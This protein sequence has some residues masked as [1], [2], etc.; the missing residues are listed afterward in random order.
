[1]TV[2]DGW[3]ERNLGQVADITMG[4][5]PDS[6]YYSEDEVGLPFLQGCAEFTA[7]FPVPKLFCSQPKKIGKTGSILFSVRAPVGKTK[8]I[9][10]LHRRVQPLPYRKLKCGTDQVDA[11]TGG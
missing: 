3:V 9:G 8:P 7:R 1:M 11:Q 6:K 2:G 5:S 4:Q 10:Q